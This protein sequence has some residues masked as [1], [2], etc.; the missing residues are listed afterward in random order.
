MWPVSQCKGCERKY[1]VGR[2]TEAVG[3]DD[4]MYYVWLEALGVSQAEIAQR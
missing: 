2:S 3:I 4:R 1:K